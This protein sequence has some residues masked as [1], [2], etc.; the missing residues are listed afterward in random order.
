M[1]WAN[2]IFG[3][4]G[5]INRSQF[6]VGI[7]AVGVLSQILTI[8]I[9]ASLYDQPAHFGYIA[10]PQ[11]EAANAMSGVI[12]L[13]VLLSLGVRRAHDIGASG[14]V[15]FVAL[16]APLLGALP[17]LFG[18]A[19]LWLFALPGALGGLVLLMALGTKGSNRYGDE[20]APGLSGAWGS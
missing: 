1:S 7:I 9:M 12:S 5:R 13:P 19:V 10:G 20:P 6:L 15:V 18:G 3:L 2:L 8:W 14:W 4:R 11:F 16:V 17:L